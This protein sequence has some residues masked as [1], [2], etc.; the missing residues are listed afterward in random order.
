LR[1]SVTGDHVEHVPLMAQARA[2]GYR[3]LATDALV[4]EHANLPEHGEVWH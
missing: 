4:V 2:L 1:Y 3:V